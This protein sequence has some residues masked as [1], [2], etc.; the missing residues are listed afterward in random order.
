MTS[1]PREFGD[2]KENP[3]IRWRNQGGKRRAYADLR[4]L[5]GGQPALI[6]P[7]EKRATT[8]PEIAELLLQQH[9]RR[10]TDRKQKQAMFAIDPDFE[11]FVDHHVEE[12]E[13]SREGRPGWLL[14][15]RTNL[16]RAVKYFTCYQHATTRNPK[17][18]P[19]PRSLSTI[20]VQD[21]RA[22][23]E[24]LKTQPNRR[25]GML[26]AQSRRHHLIALSGLFKR[27]ISERKLPV[28]SNPVT[29]MADEPVEPIR[30]T[31]WL[32]V[33]EL[34]LL[35]ESAR[36]F[37][38]KAQA[39]G[40]QPSLPCIYEF[41]ATFVLTGAQE[42]E[43]RRL[44]LGYLDF[45]SCTIHILNAATGQVDRSVP[46]HGQLREILLPYVKQLGRTT[47]HLFTTHSGEAVGD[48][49]RM[50][51]L[52]ATRAGFR[53]GQIR[54][55][56]LRTSYITHRL[57]CMEHGT[58]I[59]PYE[60]AR[61]VGYTSPA[62]IKTVYERAQHCRGTMD[63]LAFRPDAIG[64]DLQAR[65]QAVYSLPAEL[66]WGISVRTSVTRG[67]TLMIGAAVIPNSTGS[68][69]LRG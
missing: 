4:S 5:G 10:L 67:G 60:V 25:G 37:A 15:T 43:I 31:V 21:V 45:E 49:R 9:I 63:E 1:D 6:P 22:F 13:R 23:H 33:A 62:M 61:E 3:R 38:S 35:L 65:L 2:A 26:S 69:R 7:G 16:T 47:G 58:P 56:V 46:M 18:Q 17:P 14:N 28:G 53:I 36:T 39:A 24:W 40:R 64:P 50:L 48:W 42:G 30:E 59:D 55:R 27:A 66:V 34:A 41:L 57:A 19:R 11:G 68:P 29:A 52:I 44:Q 51:D 8:D 20:G 12:M 54:T 32:D